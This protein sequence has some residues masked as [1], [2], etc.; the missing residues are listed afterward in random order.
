MK[1]YYIHIFYIYL[2]DTNVSIS[3]S[4]QD[5]YGPD[6]LWVRC[7]SVLLNLVVTVDMSLL[8]SVTCPIERCVDRCISYLIL[9]PLPFV[10]ISFLYYFRWQVPSPSKANS[11]TFISLCASNEQHKNI[12]ASMWYIVHFFAL[13]FKAPFVI[14]SVVQCKLCYTRE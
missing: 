9:F 10:Y 13:K 4:E 14:R 2:W 12:F 1:S 7:E 6:K 8:S 11:I 3:Y 5:L